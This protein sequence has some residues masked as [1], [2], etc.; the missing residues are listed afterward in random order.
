MIALRHHL[1]ASF[2]ALVAACAMTTAPAALAAAPV[3]MENE[4]A[5]IVANCKLEPQADAMLHLVIADLGAGARRDGRKGGQGE[6]SA[7]LGAG[8]HGRQ[9]L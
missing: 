7:G 5:G 4:I 9:Q 8:G 3:T 1:L 2:G 6:A